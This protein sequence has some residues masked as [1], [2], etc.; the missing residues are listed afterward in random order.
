MLTTSG[1]KRRTAFESLRWKVAGRALHPQM[2]VTTDDSRRRRL[3][4]LQRC[5]RSLRSDTPTTAHSRERKGVDEGRGVNV[6]DC[7]GATMR[8]AWPTCAPGPC[9]QY[10]SGAVEGASE[11]SCHRVKRRRGGPG[12]P[13]R[14]ARVK[15]QGQHRSRGTEGVGCDE[16]KVA[17]ALREI[18]DA[19]FRSCRMPGAQLK[20]QWTWA[21]RN[22]MQIIRL[23][24]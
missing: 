9:M 18:S 10:Q 1:R 6:H 24:G 17:T 3:R 21:Q 8:T 11:W 15:S 23:G 2:Q 4:A 12:E 7:P 19:N 20:I 22:G 13:A 5:F 16:R 14:R